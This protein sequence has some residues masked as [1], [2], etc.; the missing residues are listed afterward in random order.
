MTPKEIW[1]YARDVIK[2][3]WLGGEQAIIQCTDPR[4]Y[5]APEYAYSYALQVIKGRWPE[6][7]P[8]IMQDSYWAYSYARNVIKGRWP[9]AESAI[10]PYW[11]DYIIEAAL[12]P[13]LQAAPSLSPHREKRILEL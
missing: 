2:G 3:R 8:M 9:E 12:L 13:N 11:K 10:T 4:Y 5:Y 6:A 7:E 1:L